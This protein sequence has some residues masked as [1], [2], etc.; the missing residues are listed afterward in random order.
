MKLSLGKDEMKPV[1]PLDVVVLGLSI[2]SS[3][4]NGH[5]TTYRALIG[6][7]LTMTTGTASAVA[8]PGDLAGRI[9]E[10]G[11]YKAIV[12]GI[13]PAGAGSTTATNGNGNGGGAR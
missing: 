1:R 7:G 11:P 6:G 9:R 2:T 13:A 8:A 5:A 4:G 12:A 3:W 10:L